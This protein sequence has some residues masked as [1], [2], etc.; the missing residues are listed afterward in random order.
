[1]YVLGIGLTLG[2]RLVTY[3]QVIGH[4]L[5]MSLEINV[6]PIGLATGCRCFM[7]LFRNQFKPVLPLSRVMVMY[8]N[9][10]G[11]AIPL[12]RVLEIFLNHGWMVHHL[13]T[14]LYGMNVMWWKMEI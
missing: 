7:E 3:F 13:T 2:M 1:M 12:G 10:L 14:E 4:P 9:Q 5:G 11:L 6:F 8:V